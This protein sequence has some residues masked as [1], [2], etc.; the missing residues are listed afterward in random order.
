MNGFTD[1]DAILI[2]FL[3]KYFDLFVTKI[4]TLSDQSFSFSPKKSHIWCKNH[5]FFEPCQ[6]IGSFASATKGIDTFLFEMSSA[7]TR[8]F[9]LLKDWHIASSIV[10]LPKNN[11]EVCTWG[12]ETKCQARVENC[13]LIWS[14]LKL[15]IRHEN[16]KWKS[17][18]G[19]CCTWKLSVRTIQPEA[20]AS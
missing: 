17:A 15:K 18:K 7:L 12:Q 16:W 10:I 2:I 3:C 1:K 6:N 9:C 13:W 11:Q 5:I 4:P 14:N 19:A 8:K 20:E